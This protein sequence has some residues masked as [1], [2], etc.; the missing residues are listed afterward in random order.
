M[1]FNGAPKIASL[2]SF[3]VASRHPCIT[4]R[5]APEV[6]TSQRRARGPCVTSRPASEVAASQCWA[7]SPW[8]TSRLQRAWERLNYKGYE[9]CPRQ[10][11]GPGS[12]GEPR[13]NSLGQDGSGRG[14][15]SGGL[16]RGPGLGARTPGFHHQV[17]TIPKLIPLL[18]YLSPTPHTHPKLFCPILGE[19]SLVTPLIFTHPTVKRPV[20][21]NVR[22][23]KM[24]FQATLLQ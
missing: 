12:Q 2:K 8:I 16:E 6:A 17:C 11:T 24:N 3:Y 21:F 13:A 23:L 22:K 4:S 15:G 9:Q 19:T 20:P 5:P 1:P 7:R 14:V 10:W 18:A